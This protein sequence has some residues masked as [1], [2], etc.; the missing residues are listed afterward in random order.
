LWC[1]CSSGIPTQAS[2]VSNTG[3][4]LNG[5][6][7]SLQRDTDVQYWFKYGPTTA[8]GLLTPERTIHIPAEQTPFERVS[9]PVTGLTPFTTYHYQL[10]TAP[11]RGGCLDADKTFTAGPRL[12]FTSERGAPSNGIFTRDAAGHDEAQ[13]SQQLGLQLS[14]SRDGARSPSGPTSAASRSG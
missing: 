8:Y 7:F 4:T 3:A 2:D 13:L 1:G 12:V 6:V 11:P 9:A 5:R 14:V 10:C